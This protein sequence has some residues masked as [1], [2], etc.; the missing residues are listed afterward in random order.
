MSDCA[1]THAD[2]EL[3]YPHIANAKHSI[4]RD[5]DGVR[6]SVSENVS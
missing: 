5:K 2:L 1:D 3:H 6:A 4:W